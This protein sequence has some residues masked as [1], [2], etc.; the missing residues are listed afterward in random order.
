MSDRTGDV[1]KF[2]FGDAKGLIWVWG[3]VREVVLD[4]PLL[5]PT[6]NITQKSLAG[7]CGLRL[8]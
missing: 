8:E 3:D 7:I 4:H 2:F 5:I 1:S 6:Q